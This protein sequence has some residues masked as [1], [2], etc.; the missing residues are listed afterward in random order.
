MNQSNITTGLI[1]FGGGKLAQKMGVLDPQTVLA[2]GYPLPNGLSSR[3]TLGNVAKGFV[4]EGAF[5]ELP[6]SATEQMWQNYA[7]DNP[8]M[9]GVPEASAAGL[10]AGGV[11]RA[12]K[13]LSSS[14]KNALIE[15]IQ[16]QRNELAKRVDSKAR[17][18]GI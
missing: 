9:E 4:S 12:D 17:K 7:Q 13:S 14:E 8:L 2:G 1:G 11:I 6:Q 15:E 18:S 3:Q 5:Q 16:R 10:L